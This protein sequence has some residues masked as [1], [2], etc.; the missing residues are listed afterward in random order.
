MKIISDWIWDE[1]R[2]AAITAA[3]KKAESERVTDPRAAQLEASIKK[4]RERKQR[5]SEMYLDSGD[6]IWAE[7]VKEETAFI[8]ADE[9]ELSTIRKH[10]TNPKT[11]EDFMMEI[12]NL[13]DCWNMM[14]STD[15]GRKKIVSNFVERIVVYDEY[16]DDPGRMKIELTIRTDPLGTYTEEITANIPIGVSGNERMVEAERFEL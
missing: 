6:K 5:A 16:P 9:K 7:H 2:I 11:T 10:E 12:K 14:Q 3:C 15:A 8:E 1:E 13:R 4:H